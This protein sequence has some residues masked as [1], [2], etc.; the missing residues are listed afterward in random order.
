MKTL[1]LL[2]FITLTI[3]VAPSYAQ[4][5][6]EQIKEREEI[7]KASKDELNEKVSKAARKEAKRLKKEG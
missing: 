2:L 3:G 4:L 6:K 1:K 5:S 7:L